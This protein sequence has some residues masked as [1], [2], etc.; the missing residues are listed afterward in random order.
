[1]KPKPD[2]NNAP[3]WANYLTQDRDGTWVW[4]EKK[5]EYDDGDWWAKDSRLVEDSHGSCRF[6]RL[7]VIKN[8]S[9]TYTEAGSSLEERPE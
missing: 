4:W 2:W 9:L 5:P 7:Q 6:W 3:K 1:M 8:K